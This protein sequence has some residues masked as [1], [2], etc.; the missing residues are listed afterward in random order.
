MATYESFEE[1]QAW[2][3]ARQLVNEVYTLSKNSAFGRDLGLRNQIR[4]A[5]VSVMSNVAEGFERGGTGEFV[6]FLSLAKGSAGEVRSQLYVAH[7]QGYISA[8]EFDQLASLASDTS[9][10]ISGLMSYL[11]KSGIKGTK[12]RA[13]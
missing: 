13:L 8:E 2:Q 1:L 4:R 12:Y 5:A 6:Q 10:L 7:D 11:R 9:R 3:K